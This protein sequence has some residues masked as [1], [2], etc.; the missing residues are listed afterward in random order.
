MVPVTVMVP[1]EK[2]EALN[3]APDEITNDEL[4][5]MLSRDE[6]GLGEGPEGG[7]GLSGA[8]AGQGDE[9]EPNPNPGPKLAMKQN[10][11]RKNSELAKKKSYVGVRGLRG[12]R[13]TQSRLALLLPAFALLRVLP[14]AMCPTITLCG[15]HRP[16]V[17]TSPDHSLDPL[18]A[19]P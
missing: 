2:V 3:K 12:N 6:V 7:A 1:K 15:R 5:A 18:P 14:Y 10:L 19:L 16:D 11:A 17:A 4:I 9:G 13:Q 8:R